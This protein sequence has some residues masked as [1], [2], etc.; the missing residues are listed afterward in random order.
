MTISL[1]KLDNESNDVECTLS[2]KLAIF[3]PHYII[4]SSYGPV[5]TEV[6][7]TCDHTNGRNNNICYQ[8]W[9][10]LTMFEL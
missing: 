1:F 10:V 8:K 5:G 2:L 7:I 3:F 9:Y 6:V 4:G